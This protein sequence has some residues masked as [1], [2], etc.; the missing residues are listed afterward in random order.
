MENLVVG[1][2]SFTGRHIVE[3]EVGRG[4]AVTLFNRGKGNME[5][6]QTSPHNR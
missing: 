1:G 3:E 2:T 6:F 4:H 5:T